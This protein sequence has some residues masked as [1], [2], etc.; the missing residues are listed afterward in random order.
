MEGLVLRYMLTDGNVIRYDDYSQNM[1]T[2]ILYISILL[3]H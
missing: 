3:N 2:L 1:A